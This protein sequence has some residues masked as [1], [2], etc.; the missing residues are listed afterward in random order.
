M[1]AT[2]STRISI[3]LH[4]LK[5]RFVMARMAKVSDEWQPNMTNDMRI[6]EWKMWRASK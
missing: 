3:F 1:Q 5:R 2:K 4:Q 6:S